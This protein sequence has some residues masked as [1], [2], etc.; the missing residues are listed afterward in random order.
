MTYNAAAQGQTPTYYPGPPSSNGMAMQRP[1]PHQYGVPPNPGWVQPQ[2]Q[3]VYSQAPGPPYGQ[4]PPNG[5][6]APPPAMTTMNGAPQHTYAQPPGFAAP[7]PQ[8]PQKLLFILQSKNYIITDPISSRVLFTAVRASSVSSFSS[9]NQ[10]HMTVHR[11]DASGPE[12]ATVHYHTF[13]TSK[14]DVTLRLG[15]TGGSNNQRYKKDFD[16]A[17]SLGRLRWQ[18]ESSS[19][20]SCSDKGLKLEA[21]T[22]G[23]M[24]TI[25]KFE[26]AKGGS[27][28][29]G[30]GCLTI[31]ARSPLNM[32]QLE[33]VVAT[34][35]FERER[36]RRE[37]ETES[38]V[39]GVA[40]AS[41]AV[42]AAAGGS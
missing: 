13:T 32:M 36:R 34:C 42:A 3:P 5:C 18:N 38:A 17:T 4:V 11:G 25:A 8:L 2:H 33:E 15:G 6:P 14:M 21:S 31:L 26:A 1:P 9:S 27:K 16:S 19:L 37:S 7:P 23:Y 10:P 24:G 29:K 41:G 35:V 12:V 20:F 28:T 30:D 40:D 22:G 39:G